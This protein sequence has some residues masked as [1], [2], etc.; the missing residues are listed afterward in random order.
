MSAR[1]SPPH[2]AA[3]AQTETGDSLQNE[4]VATTRAMT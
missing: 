2:M 1:P 3:T 4:S